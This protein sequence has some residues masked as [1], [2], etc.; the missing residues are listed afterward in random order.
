MRAELSRVDRPVMLVPM[1]AHGGA[2]IDPHPI[3]LSR[4]DLGW[5]G[6]GSVGFPT[7]PERR[8]DYLIL[9]TADDKEWRVEKYVADYSRDEARARIVTILGPVCEKGVA[10]RISRWL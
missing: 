9:D 7:N 4:E 1:E 10:E 2:G 3:R 5:I 8:A 6:T